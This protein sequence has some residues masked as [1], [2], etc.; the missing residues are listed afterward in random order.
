MQA[1]YL[2]LLIVMLSVLA[3]GAAFAAHKA[4]APLQRP[5]VRSPVRGIVR[6]SPPALSASQNPLKRAR[7]PIS[8]IDV[9]S[10]LLTL[11]VH[12]GAAP[13]R[14]DASTTVFLNGRNSS[15]AELRVGQTVCATYEADDA[16]SVAQWIEPC[17]P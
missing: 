17:A 8:A 5:E 15:V 2:T 9:R 16:A 3:L 4:Q 10:G 1:R 7:G 13:M 6:A 14:V 12:E 11:H